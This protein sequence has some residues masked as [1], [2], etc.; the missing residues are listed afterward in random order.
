MQAESDSADL[1]FLL[2][3]EVGTGNIIEDAFSS[4]DVA[5]EA[6]ASL[7]VSWVLFHKPGGRAPSELTCGG[8]SFGHYSIRRHVEAK[9]RPTSPAVPSRHSSEAS[10][11]EVVMAGTLEQKLARGD[12]QNDVRIVVLVRTA[13]FVFRSSHVSIG[14]HDVL[15]PLLA[16][17]TRIRASLVTTASTHAGGRADGNVTGA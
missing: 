14:H 12:G 10:E 17:V 7:W 3:K 13:S 9:H 15:G 16:R 6:A 4:E 11:A 2:V 1:P 5:R 8:M